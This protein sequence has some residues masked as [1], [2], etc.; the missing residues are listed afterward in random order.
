[1]SVALAW[2]W[3][4]GGPDL[5]VVVNPGMSLG[6]GQLPKYNIFFIGVKRN[7]ERYKF[8]EPRPPV[9]VVWA[10]NQ[11]SWLSICH[12][13]ADVNFLVTVMKTRL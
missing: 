10:R 2:A 5:G 12:V 8:W 7:A 4:W 9:D 11:N 6:P 3:A 1:M 13:Q